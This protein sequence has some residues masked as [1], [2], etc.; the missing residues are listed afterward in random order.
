MPT[1][2]YLP[3]LDLN[4]LDWGSNNCLGVALSSEVFLWHAQTGKVDRLMQTQD[5]E[6]VTSVKWIGEGNILAVGLDNG[7]VEVTIFI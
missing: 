1:I 7:N 3:C 4:I 2:F 5:E 6:V